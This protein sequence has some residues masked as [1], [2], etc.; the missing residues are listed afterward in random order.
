MMMAALN[1]RSRPRRD[2]LIVCWA[3]S[4]AAV[5]VFIALSSGA[6]G[7]PPQAT[8][9]PPAASPVVQFNGTQ[10]QLPLKFPVSR[11]TGLSL[12]VDPRWTNNY[13]YRPVEVTISSPNPTTV[14][15]VIT[16]ELHT[17]HN[18]N[19]SVKQSFEMPAGSTKATTTVSLPVF[20]TPLNNFFWDLRVDG[21]KD[22]DLSVDYKS[23]QAWM[24]GATSSGGN[25]TFLVAGPNKTH[26]SLVSTN[27]LELEVL[28]LNL[29]AFPTRWIDY[30]AIDVVSLSLAEVQQLAK[31]SP[32]TFE[33]IRK[34]VAAGGQL[35]VSDVGAELE[36]LPDV[37]TLLQLPETLTL[38]EAEGTKSQ[39]EADADAADDAEE[40]DDTA[41]KPT[42]PAAATDDKDS[43]PAGADAKPADTDAKADEAA[44]EANENSDATTKKTSDVDEHRVLP[45]W[46]SI[47]FRRGGTEGQ[48]ITFLD[49]RTGTRRTVRDPE[50]I[51]RLQTDPN[52]VTAEQRFE[53]TESLVPRRFAG[54]SNQWFVE[55]GSGLGRVRAFRGANEAAQFPLAPAAANPNAVANSDAPDQLPRALAMG[56][57]RTQRWDSR[58]G[59]TPDS[60]NVEFAKFLVP[61]VGL[62]PVTEFRILITL[63]V[64]LIG[65]INYWLLKRYKR[66]HLMVL[67]VPLAAIVTTAALF[68]YAIVADGFE[69]RVR[70]QSYTALD[71]VTGDAACW[72]R[73]SYYSGLSP[74]DGLTMPADVVMY[75][76]L[77]SWTGDADLAEEKDLAWDGQQAK[78]TKG[79][80]NSRTPT[81]YLTVR[82]RKSPLRLE[83]L[84]SGDKLRVKNQLDTKIKALVVISDSGKLYF[85]ENI[86]SDASAGL[87]PVER[88]DAIRRINRLIV[89]HAPQAPDALASSESDLATMR[90]RSRYGGYGR[91]GLQYNPGKLSENLEGEALINLAG[92]GG[93]PALSLPPRTYVAI[94]E[95]GPEVETGIS[96]AKEEASFHVIVGKF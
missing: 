82:S 26:R 62:A 66:L 45:G 72:T 57:R 6:A 28:S 34:W 35:W 79:W 41:A 69:S 90:S 15:H 94:T 85:G 27:A 32:T 58:H 14:D 80:L 12:N 68:G 74:R 25:L 53:P 52:L 75:P 88:D 71:Q 73:L 4:I 86:T 3:A 83:V 46:H 18:R 93:Q 11:R 81:Q 36:H 54:D 5:V 91:N 7:Q 51:A 21:I 55:Q 1:D 30:T 76:I 49:M 84:D 8:P 23:P 50:V 87:Q 63:F 65:P 24:S 17:G 33:A 70:A 64:L 20:Q 96:Y 39:E 13:G 89:E 19:V 77:P 61:G 37:S 2:K 78:L 95:T 67:T 10:T 9:T 47:R 48:V 42:D 22:K 29:S 31:Q 38:V 43:T 59:M 92:L 16:I 44:K 56:L 60:A 40:K